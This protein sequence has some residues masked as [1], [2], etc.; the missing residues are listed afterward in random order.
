M[1]F[2][3]ELDVRGKRV[4]LRVDFN[5]PLTEQG[6]IR[7]DTRIRAS[8]PT[9]TYLLGHGAKLVIASHL[10]RPKGK[11]DPKMSLKP[12]AARLASLIPN[13]VTQ[14]PEVVG[15]EVARLKK[16]L[17]E[18]E[19]LLLENV[20]FTKAETDNDEAF[21]KQLAENIDVFV[22]DAFGSCH[23]AHASVVAIARFVKEKAAG[24]LLKKEV[25]YLRKAV[26]E[27]A[28][29]YVAI[30][31]G[32]KVEDKIPVIENLLSKADDILIGGAMAYT[33]LKAQGKDVGKSLV[34]DDKLD[35]AR[36]ILKKAS[37]K[38]VN[39]L[40]P[41]DHVLAAAVDAGAE[42]EVVESPPFP[43]DKMGVDI[44]PKTVAA[45]AKIIAGART[46]VWNGPLGVF[47]IDKFAKGTIGIAAAVAASG[48]ISIVGGGDS[49]A[50]VK[51]AGV[52][53]KIS[54]ISTGGGASLEFLAYETL[55]G[56]DAL[57][58]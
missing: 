39:F 41:L 58:D 46:I 37:E 32:A 17:R 31:G 19:V 2:V 36:T 1:R 6:E 38:K 30:L 48:A 49:I 24:Y 45:Y 52:T 40:L 25:D 18:G 54:H 3:E 47:E 7:D 34:E 26:H 53:E 22:N 29:P 33:F 43:A 21:A 51:K 12:A 50:A 15:T 55:P 57:E 9:I 35:I 10:G 56:I 42:T 44:G 5:V 28:K 8:L 16:E 13:K 11:V 14:A 27:P 20:R 23:R 4:F